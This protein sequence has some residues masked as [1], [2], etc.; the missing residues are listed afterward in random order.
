MHATDQLS[1]RFAETTAIGAAMDRLRSAPPEQLL[2]VPVAYEDLRPGAD[3]VRLS[4][5]GLRVLVRPS[6]T[7]PKLKAY[8]EVVLAPTVDVPRARVQAADR[9]AGLRTEVS[10]VLAP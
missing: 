10:A 4:G 7:E 9:L 1:L 8:L 5:G 2:D 6:G 3:V